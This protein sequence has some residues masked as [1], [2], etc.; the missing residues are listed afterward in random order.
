[1]TRKHSRLLEL[2]KNIDFLHSSIDWNNVFCLTQ[3]GHCTFSK[4]KKINSDLFLP[5]W[6]LTTYKKTV[7]FRRANTS[8]SIIKILREKKN[9]QIIRAMARILLLLLVWIL[10]HT[11]GDIEQ[12]FEQSDFRGRGVWFIPR[13]RSGILPETHQQGYMIL[14]W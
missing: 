4:I 13:R 3:L 1:M 10:R 6:I 14:K 7:L 5:R 12:R 8:I 9:T 11:L 2:Q